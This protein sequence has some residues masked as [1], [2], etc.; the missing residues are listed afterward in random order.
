MINFRTQTK[1]GKSVERVI[2]VVGESPSELLRI[3]QDKGR[4]MTFS[5]KPDPRTARQA[6]PAL[7]PAEDE[8]ELRRQAEH[9]LDTFVEFGVNLVDQ[10]DLKL[11]TLD[12]AATLQRKLTKIHRDSKTAIEEQGV[13]ILF[14]S[15]GCLEWIDPKT[16]DEIRRAPLIMLPVLL[17][18]TKT[19][20]FRLR[21]DGGELG[22]NLSIASLMKGQFGITL[23]PL[24]EDVIALDYFASV[25]SAIRSKPDWSV[26]ES[27][28]A[29]G[30]L[31]YAKYLMYRDLDQSA[32][33]RERHPAQHPLTTA[34]LDTGFPTDAAGIDEDEYLDPHRPAE[35]ACDVYDADASQTLAILEA[36]TGRSMIIEGPPGTGKSQTITNLIAEFIRDGKKVLF[37]AEKMAALEVVHRRLQ[38]AHLNDAC[39]ELHSNK[40]NKRDFYTQ[41]RRTVEVA[42]PK[43]I[44]AEGEVQKIEARRTQLTGHARA[45]NDHLPDRG[46]APR[47]IMGR[48]LRLGPEPSPEGRHDF[49]AMRGWNEADFQRCLVIVREL[50]EQVARMGTP[51]EHPW[52]GCI[53]DHLLPQDKDDIGRLL[54][55]ASLAVER[56][57]A[58]SCG[59]AEALCVDLPVK[60]ADIDSL[61]DCVQLTVN[62]PEIEG[63]QIQSAD[64][65]ALE[66][67]LRDLFAQ[68]RRL[69]EARDELSGQAPDAAH[70]T[71][72]EKTSSD[73]RL[74][75]FFKEQPDSATPEQDD[76]WL[77]AIERAYAASISAHEL[78]LQ[79]SALLGTEPPQV[80][81]QLDKLA[82]VA[83][84]IA[85]EPSLRGVAVSDTNWSES[86]S[87]IRE[88]IQAVRQWQ[89]AHQTHESSL[90]ETA[91]QTDVA[92]NLRTLEE[93][94]GRFLKFL[95]GAYRHAMRATAPLFRTPSRSPHDRIESLRAVLSARE[96]EGVVS[97]HSARCQT[98]L[99]GHWRG[100]DSDADKLEAI[101]AWVQEL[102]ALAGANW[103]STQTLAALQRGVDEKALSELGARLRQAIAAVQET[104]TRLLSTAASLKL[105]DSASTHGDRESLVYRHLLDRLRPVLAEVDRALPKLSKKPLSEKARIIALIQ[106]SQRLT[107]TM[108][109]T[110]PAL[111]APLGKRWQA[112]ESDWASCI[113]LLDWALALREA[114]RRGRVPEGM[115]QFFEQERPRDGMME[116]AALSVSGRRAAQGAVQRVLE[117]A[118]LQE[119]PAQFSEQPIAV[120]RERIAG[121]RRTLDELPE[122][123]R[124]NR[125]AE[126]ADQAG[127]AESVSLAGAWSES[128]TRLAEA[129]ERSWLTG[130]MREAVLQRPEIARFDRV[131]HEEAAAEFRRLDDELMLLNRI[132]V[133][134]EHWRQVPRGIAAGKMGWLRAQFTMK[135]R[136]KP[137]RAAMEHA[138]EA[139]QAI[140]PVFLMSPL[141][142]AMYLPSN[143]PKFDVVIFDEASQVKPEDAFGSIL[144]SAQVIVV[145]D[146]KQM[147]PTSFF[148]KLTSDGDEEE[149]EDAED[150]ANSARDL[151][152]VLGLMDRKIPQESPSRRYLRWHYRSLH[153]SL[154]AT[155]NALFYDDK[156]I[157][158]PSLFRP[159][160]TLGLSLRHDPSTVYG[161][162]EKRQNPAEARAVALAAQTHI[163]ENPHLTLGIA[164]FSKAQQE[165]LQDEI[166]QLRMDDPSFEEFD[167]RHPYEPLFIKN[168]ENVQGDERD[169]IFISVG[170][171][172]DAQGKISGHF[173]PVNRNG[174]ERR[175]NVLLT[176]ARNQCVIFSNLRAD[177]IPVSAASGAGV[178]ALRTFL[179][180]AETGTLSTTHQAENLPPAPF[181]QVVFERLRAAG[182]NVASG[183]G[184]AGY[185]IDLA[186]RHPDD[187]DR[188]VLGV[189][190]DGEMY[191]R[192]RTTR[193]R[194]KLRRKVLL[195][196]GWRLHRIW[197]YDWFQNPEREWARL[198]EAIRAAVAGEEE[199][200]R[201]PEAAP[202]EAESAAPEAG[203]APALLPRDPI[204][205]PRITAHPY[206]ICQLGADVAGSSLHDEPVEELAR[207]VLHVIDTESP[208][209]QDEIVRR[210]REAAGIK[211]AGSR[212]QAAIQEAT[213][214][215]LRHSRA[216]RFG[217]FLYSVRQPQIQVRTRAGCPAALR[218]ID[219]IAPEEIA[220]ALRDV[221]RDS[222]GIAPPEAAAET[223]RRF[224]FDRIT[225]PM[226]QTI[227]AVLEA[228]VAAG[229]LGLSSGHLTLP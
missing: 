128:K 131:T 103:I 14:L 215:V 72:W 27:F 38:E 44:S 25:A 19:G 31:S 197:S 219:L 3:L 114:V 170:Y 33:P 110:S 127:L 10:N 29:L 160:S 211:R 208:I 65:Q 39:L 49:A 226:S 43:M 137:I 152:S 202:V 17:D 63:A 62:A 77:D 224:G 220:L 165:A 7:I 5:G 222:F 11:N 46:I 104:I 97:R 144:R 155:S 105:S 121:W 57:H 191:D 61:R 50:Q 24:P 32:W 163:R 126:E 41:L 117:I 203:I 134:R 213:D 84:R 59:L 74:K 147:P 94:G 91:W 21:W 102:H 182:H 180:F 60:P 205:P 140:K 184:S 217:A 167:K 135:T 187:P 210:I 36:K 161:R 130:L 107:Q 206:A 100:V 139:V 193:D 189:E 30:F 55:D 89:V 87:V 52:H 195:S 145:G 118:G 175:L 116:A 20:G 45:V 42:S 132:H 93:Q 106:E 190:C 4:A 22:E 214:L 129:F 122:L 119:D 138:G 9:E 198:E 216:R 153:E 133:A 223:A 228:E 12:A 225:A 201:L 111:S 23:P 8:D 150:A 156:L 75:S 169:V 53:L 86:R 67:P 143:G 108:Q 88:A 188:F 40:A 183:V 136:H 58:Q 185:A 212:I 124:W 142:V 157:T 199:P 92:A 76:A 146:T 69:D 227:L 174:G 51:N 79:T 56:F 16:P 200:P 109:S 229:R 179:A 85:G 148:D 173:G 95:N 113:G 218:N 178:H 47:D 70:S 90:H 123:I 71:A 64:W 149:D 35:T 54:D 48:L 115:L 141:S 99:G 82:T 204:A 177:D 2:E 221:V 151:E 158:F 164:A 196:R 66:A 112:A 176:R 181:D 28:V 154:I 186:I 73:L 68:G 207:W 37:V 81:A 166:D 209:H 168:L 34:L 194:D 13:N 83:A 1:A 80:L 162:G 120:Q 98:L 18:R 78:S 192:A 172:R 159:G 96:A 15:L 125:L 171:G 26:D 101:D 6:S